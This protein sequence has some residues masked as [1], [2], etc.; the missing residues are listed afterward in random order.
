MRTTRTRRGI[1][2]AYVLLAS[3]LGLIRLAC[4]LFVDYRMK[5]H[6]MTPFSYGLRSLLYPEALLPLHTSLGRIENG[7][8][9]LALFSLIIVAGTFVMLSPILIL[10]IYPLAP[11][12]ESYDTKI[13]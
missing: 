5:S 10:M 9:F 12:T 4:L 6:I 13:S 3:T 7:G 2:L 1:A 11:R 8:I